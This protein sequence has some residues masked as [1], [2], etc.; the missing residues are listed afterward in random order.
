VVTSY[1]ETVDC[2]HS[3]PDIR[4]PGILILALRPSGERFKSQ[5]RED[6]LISPAVQHVTSIDDLNT[7]NR[8]GCT[9]QLFRHQ[10]LAF[11]VSFVVKVCM[12]LGFSGK[13]C[14]FNVTSRLPFS[15]NQRTGFDAR[16]CDLFRP[17]SK[18]DGHEDEGSFVS[19]RETQTSIA[20]KVFRMCWK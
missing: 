13:W 18:S 12:M 5:E 16:G 19:A 20:F 8:E 11:D 14:E 15:P 4:T 6:A 1:R 10:P 17:P 7:S 2:K 3:T 9:A